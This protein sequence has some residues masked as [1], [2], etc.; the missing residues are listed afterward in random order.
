MHYTL[1]LGKC[2]PPKNG[3]FRLQFNFSNKKVRKQLKIL[4]EHNTMQ[5]SS[6]LISYLYYLSY[7]LSTFCALMCSFYVFTRSSH[8]IIKWTFAELYYAAWVFAYFTST[9]FHFGKILEYLVGFPS[10][11]LYQSLPLNTQSRK[12]WKKK[13]VIKNTQNC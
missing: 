7:N 11:I 3:I 12:R 1:Y 9:I 4:W 13:K 8:S 6:L 5:I 2:S 10:Q